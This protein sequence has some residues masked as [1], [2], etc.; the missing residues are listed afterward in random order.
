MIR[1]SQLFCYKAGRF[2]YFLIPWS[3]RIR[4]NSEFFWPE[5]FCSFY[6]GTKFFFGYLIIKFFFTLNA[7]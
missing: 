2:L 3:S 1:L 5:L 6:F 4:T 7:Y